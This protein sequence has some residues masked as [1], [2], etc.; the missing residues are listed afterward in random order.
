VTSVIRRTGYRLFR[1][2][3]L[4]VRIR[5]VRALTPNF[6]VGAV[7]LLRDPAGALLLLRQPPGFGWSLP[8]G[9]LDRREEPA[10][11]AAREL[12]EE[13]GIELSPD[14]LTPT[15]PNA[16]INVTAQ[17]IDAVFTATVDR[18]ATTFELD[19]VEVLEAGWFAPAALPPLTV[20][21]A[22]LLAIYGMGPYA[23]FGPDGAPLRTEAGAPLDPARPTPD[24]PADR[25][26]NGP[27]SPAR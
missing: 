18:D 22:R 2:L 10:H 1:S 24:D 12:R 9:L 5:L 20:A 16:R 17:Q 14:A 21:T 25:P 15:Q 19:P 11:A 4:R 8:G 13:T 3:P 26:A 6:T 27:V 7:V 23:S